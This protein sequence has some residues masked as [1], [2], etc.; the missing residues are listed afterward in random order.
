MRE[1]I[2]EALDKLR[3]NLQADG[4]DIKLVDINEDGVVQVKFEGACCG[5][6]NAQ[7]TLKHYIEKSLKDQIKEVKEVV[8]V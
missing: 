6:P 5:C 4:G 1:K 8:M 7:I 2:Q 3:V